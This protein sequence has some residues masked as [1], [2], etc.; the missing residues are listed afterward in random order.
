MIVAP[1]GIPSPTMGDPRSALVN[2][3]VDVTV[4]VEF[5]VTDTVRPGWLV[6][7]LYR[8]VSDSHDVRMLFPPIRN[9]T[10]FG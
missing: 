10:L 8:N 3:A 6:R 2:P 9:P 5:V 1:A 7:K 4:V